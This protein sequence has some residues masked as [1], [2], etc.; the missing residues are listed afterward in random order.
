MRITNVLDKNIDNAEYIKHRINLPR[1]IVEETKLLDKEITA[2]GREMKK[3]KV[4]Y[5]TTSIT[6]FIKKHIETLKKS[7]RLDISV[8]T[9][10]G[11]FEK[12][13]GIIPAISSLKG[14]IKFFV[15][16]ISFLIKSSNKT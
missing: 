9:M 16:T 7:R 8:C 3:I 10:D 12:Y 5:A 13:G 4:L 11:L 1:K 15:A 6:P 2:S 14:K